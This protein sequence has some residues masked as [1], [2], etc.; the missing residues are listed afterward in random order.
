MI[1][2]EQKADL[3]AD[4]P[5]LAGELPPIRCPGLEGADIDQRD[6]RE[7]IGVHCLTLPVGS[8]RAQSPAGGSSCAPAA[9]RFGDLEFAAAAITNIGRDGELHSSPD[10]DIV[11]SLRGNQG[12]HHDSTYMPLQARGA[13]FTAEI[14]PDTGADTA[15]ADMRAAYDALDKETKA[16]IA[17]LR[18]YHSLY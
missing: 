7:F 9:R 16:L 8:I 13:V 15:W 17:D 12:W 3:V 18:T 1:D 11:K 10:D 6:L 2:D 14:V 4:L 5:N